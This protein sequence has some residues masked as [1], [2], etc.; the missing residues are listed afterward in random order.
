MVAVVVAG[1]FGAS[2]GQ[3][4]RVCRKPVK[5]SRRGLI[6][7]KIMK[8]IFSGLVMTCLLF[9]ACKKNINDNEAISEEKLRTTETKIENGRLSFSTIAAYEQFLNLSDKESFVKS[10]PGSKDFISFK[11]RNVSI[12]NQ[13]ARSINGCDVPEELIE[14][15]PVF[16]NMLD[17][18][19]IVQINGTV[20]R[21]DYCN[22]KMWVMN[23]TNALDPAIYQNF[24]G[25]VETAGVVGSFP[26]YV[27]VL[28]AVAQ[29][30]KTMPDPATVTG[31]EIFQSPMP[32]SFLGPDVA[33]NCYI[34]N[35]QKAPKDQ[36]I[37]MDGKLE[38]AQF[39]IYF[40]LYGKEKY[41]TRCLINWC[42]SSNSDRNW[43]VNYSYSFRRKGKNSD[44]SGTGQASPVGY[45]QNE[46][47]QTVY[48][49]SRG[50]RW[51]YLQ[52]DVVNMFTNKL[53]V[54]RNGGS[55][56]TLIANESYP[57]FRNVNN[58]Q[59]QNGVN[60]FILRF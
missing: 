60:H 24:M 23:S 13:Q 51:A 53:K 59:F 55:A 15:N 9:S 48:S 6:N 41:K 33:E 27:D 37:L 21:Y 7:H 34:N 40:H 49:F 39:A 5:E 16:F 36:N 3:M 19:G 2:F 17:V 43:R 35:N 8:N 32:N 42:T 56:W 31:N 10:L 30:Y 45:N 1:S 52:W 20:Y 11:N 50:L 58:F 18:N 22:N 38:Y 12:Q 47:E 28:E 57:T 29:G 46:L 26:N 25:G 44:D 4:L 14:N 54:E